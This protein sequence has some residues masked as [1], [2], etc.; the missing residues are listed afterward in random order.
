[1][2]EIDPS[3]MD[4]IIELPHDFV[5]ELNCLVVV[6]H[7]LTRQAID[8]DEEKELGKIVAGSADD[9]ETVRSIEN[10]INNFYEDLRRAANNLTMV[11][12]VTRIQHWMAKFVKHLAGHPKRNESRLIS[13]MTSWMQS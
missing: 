10:S 9:P 3:W 4:E 12:L 11:A 7:D 1:M 13:D 6:N 8:S 5:V 2:T